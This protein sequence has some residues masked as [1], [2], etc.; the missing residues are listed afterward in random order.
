M[1]LVNKFGTAGQ[2]ALDEQD[3]SPEQ[4]REVKRLQERDREVRAHEQAHIAA[5]GGLATGPTFTTQQGPDGRSYAIGGEVQIDTS[6][7]GTPKETIAKAQIIRRAALA[8]AE[9]SAQDLSVAASA[10]QMEIQARADLVA[11]ELARTQE[12]AAQSSEV[13]QDPGGVPTGIGSM[14]PADVAGIESRDQGGVKPDDGFVGQTIQSVQ[15][16]E[17]NKAPE[18]Q[19][20]ARLAGG[21]GKAIAA[22]TLAE[23]AYQGR[24]DYIALA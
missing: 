13:A 23:N 19:S 14:S 11:E 18:Q 20:V 4:L 1:E 10:S 2:T 15:E 5:A 8:P 12:V 21:Q 6:A 17:V 9:P 7:A 24:G 3:L 16:T 22:Y